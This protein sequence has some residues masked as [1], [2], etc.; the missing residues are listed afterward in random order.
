[1]SENLQAG[2]HAIDESSSRPCVVHVLQ[3]IPGWEGRETRLLCVLCPVEYEERAGRGYTPDP[4]TVDAHLCRRPADR[5]SIRCE[6]AGDPA[7]PVPPTKVSRRQ[8]E[9]LRRAGALDGDAGGA[10]DE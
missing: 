1:M 7:V 3:V 2:D 6:W 8:Y 9:A 5:A 4:F 10:G